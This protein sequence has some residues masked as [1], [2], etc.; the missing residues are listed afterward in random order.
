VIW[1]ECEVK[2]LSLQVW[3]GQISLESLDNFR[4]T[5]NGFAHHSRPFASARF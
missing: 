3:T 1:V 5:R 2:Y 4:F